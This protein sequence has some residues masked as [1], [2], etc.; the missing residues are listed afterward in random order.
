MGKWREVGEE[1]WCSFF[2]SRRRH[3][4]YWR[5]WSSDVCSS[6]LP[7]Q[8]GTPG[9]PNSTLT[10]H[11]GPTFAASGHSPIIPQPNQAVTVNVSASDPAG[12]QALTLWWSINGGAWPQA[13]MGPAPAAGPPGYA[14]YVALIPG[15]TA[16]ALVQ[17]YV[18]ATDNL[19]ASTTFPARGPDSCALF[20]VDDG[21]A[22]M[23]QLHRLRL[24][25]TPP[26]TALLL[27]DRNV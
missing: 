10:A 1:C 24:L 2:S 22:P 12:V 21:T 19:G 7:S 20:K 26:D 5:D 17:F 6:D 25:M 13:P 18:T 16:G 9:G 8:H 15:Q 11:L 23:P 27:A 14:N 3:T 4:R